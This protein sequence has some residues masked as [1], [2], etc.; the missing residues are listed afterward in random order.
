MASESD[1]RMD[2]DLQAAIA[3]QSAAL[4]RLVE[5]LTPV[6]QAR[7][8]HALLRWG[9]SGRSIRPE[10]ED[11]TQEVF[12]ALFAEEGKLLRSWDP[13]R[14]LSLKNFV[15]LIAYRQAL[16]VLRSRK[17]S[18]WAEVPAK[19]EL[20]ESEAARAGGRE[21]DIEQALVTKDVLQ[22]LYAAMSEQLSPLGRQLFELLFVEERS[23]N[24][25]CGVM[26]MTPDAVYAWRSRLP[27]LAR[28]LLGQILNGAEPCQNSA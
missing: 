21:A 19:D 28:S 26:D 11:L 10:V 14:G 3:G 7:V 6:I 15:G 25:V 16:S 18:G 1:Q 9:R 24:E 13:S 12:C 27:R 22:R 4:A 23:V 20:F 5:E 2:G 17:R 8:A